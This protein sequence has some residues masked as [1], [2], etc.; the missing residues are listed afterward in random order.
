[1]L[2]AWLF[3]FDNYIKWFSSIEPFFIPT[4]KSGGQNE[5][6]KQYQYLCKVVFI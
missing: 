1:M 6:Q 2:L 4:I 3:N 5:S